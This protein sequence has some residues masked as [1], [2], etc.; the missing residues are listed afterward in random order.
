MNRCT[1]LIVDDDDDLVNT[2]SEILANNGIKIVDT[3]NNGKIAAELYQKHRPSIVLLDMKMA[4]FDGNYAIKHIYEF[5]PDAK[6][7]VMT[8]YPE[9]EPNLDSVTAVM[10]KP[11]NVVDLLE[12]IQDTCDSIK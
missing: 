9:I 7:I 8:A 2:Y 4:K 3:C 6:I 11:T 12:L 1:V 5:D 10:Q